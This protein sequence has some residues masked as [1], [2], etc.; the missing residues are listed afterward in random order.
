[1]A[2]EGRDEEEWRRYI[3]PVI[4]TANSDEVVQIL[5]EPEDLKQ[6]T[7]RLI[8]G[9]WD[10]FYCEEFEAREGML[11]EAERVARS[12][13]SRGFGLAFADL[14]G[15]RL[16]ATLAAG[17][18]TVAH[19]TFCPSAHLGE[20]VSYVTYPPHLVVFFAAQHVTG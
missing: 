2:P 1:A 4:T 8:D 10:S 14:T 19:V 13:A 17:L 16:P 11:R 7:I 18:S 9:I 3:E 6:R 15:N 12:I 20:F 5:L